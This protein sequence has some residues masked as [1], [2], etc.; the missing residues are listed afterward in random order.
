[1]NI[2]NLLD[3]KAIDCPSRGS[4]QF[5]MGRISTSETDNHNPFQTIFLSF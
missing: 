1:M 5:K 4:V 3:K 2:S